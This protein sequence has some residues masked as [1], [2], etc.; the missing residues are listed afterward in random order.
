VNDSTS[1]SLAQAYLKAGYEKV[2]FLKGGVRGA[3]NDWVKAEYPMEP[4]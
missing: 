3:W 2:Y 4:K 1:A